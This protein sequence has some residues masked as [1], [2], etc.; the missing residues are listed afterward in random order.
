MLNWETK[1]EANILLKQGKSIRAIAKELCLSRNTVRK[2]IRQQELQQAPRKNRPSKLDPF[3]DYL[4]HRLYSAGPYFLPATVLL[5]EV[6]TMG[7]SGG[8]TILKH[9][10]NI[11]RGE[12]KPQEELIRF[13]TPPGQQMQ[14]DWTIFHKR[15]YLGAFV[16][17]LGYSRKAYVEFVQDEEKQ[18]LLQCHENAFD[19][20]GGVPKEGLYDN[21]K[22]VVIQ[23]D[24]YGPGKHGFQQTFYDFAKH[25]GFI[26]RLCRPYRAKTKGKVERFNRYLKESFYYPLVTL[27]PEIKDDLLS[28]NFEVKKW[29]LEIAD[30][31]LLKERESRSPQQLFAEEQPTLQL[32]PTPYAPLKRHSFARDLQILQHDLKMYDQLVVF[33]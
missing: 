30:H 21:M 15:C 14:V 22:T 6:Q 26:P 1:L 25:H 5:R 18:T 7:Y 11:I 16:V 28:L 24:K 32:L 4:R 2:A 9:F 17:I 27:K 13:E 3:K 8:I 23:R 33:L 20:F 12:L 29:L 10:L 19:Y 31:R